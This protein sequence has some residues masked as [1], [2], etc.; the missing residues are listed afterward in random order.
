MPA[1]DPLSGIV[2]VDPTRMLVGPHCTMVLNDLGASAIEAE[3][4]K[5][6]RAPEL[7]G[8]RAAILGELMGRS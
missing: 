4:P 8:D 1:A 2:A 6:E 7:D 5:R 3:P